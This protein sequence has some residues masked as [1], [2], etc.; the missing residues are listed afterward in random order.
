LKPVTKVVTTRAQASECTDT[1]ETRKR[2]IACVN[3]DCGAR[4]ENESPIHHGSLSTP[5]TV[6]RICQE[7]TGTDWQT[8]L[9]IVKYGTERRSRQNKA[10]V[11][12]EK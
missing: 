12:E 8:V 10:L 7:K 4:K 2:K 5:A 6:K 3:A 11:I 1:R 9:D